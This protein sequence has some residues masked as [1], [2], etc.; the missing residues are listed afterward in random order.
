[1]LHLPQAGIFFR[2]G[3]EQAV[4]RK[5]CAMT[6]LSAITPKVVQADMNQPGNKDSLA[7][8][9]KNLRK[10]RMQ[11]ETLADPSKIGKLLVAETTLLYNSNAEIVQTAG[12]LD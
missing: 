9:M 2:N 4:R 12:S 7:E 10:L 3:G 1:L 11:R 6:E 5:E 8:E